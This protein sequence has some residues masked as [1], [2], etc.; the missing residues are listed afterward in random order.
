MARS[1]VRRFDFVRPF[2]DLAQAHGGVESV[3]NGQRHGHVRDDGPGP[4]AVK[5]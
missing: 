5:V 1:H 4:Q 2:P 3:E